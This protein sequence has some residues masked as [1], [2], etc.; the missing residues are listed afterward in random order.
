MKRTWRGWSARW[1]AG[2]ALGT[3]LAVGAC[4]APRPSDPCTDVQCSARGY[5]VSDHGRAYC[6]CLFG[7]HPEGLGCVANDPLDPCLGVTCDGHGRCVDVGGRPLCDCEDGYR[8]P[9]G[10][11]VECVL[12]EGGACE[13]GAAESCNGRDDD[14][15]GLTD[16]VFD[17]DFDSR[18]CGACG[19]PCGTA[20]H[21]I[22]RCTLGDCE[23]TC[24]PGWSDLDRDD[25]NGCEATCE[26]GPNPADDR[27]DGRDDDCDGETDE[28]WS[29]PGGDCGLGIC[30]RELL[31]HRGEV[32]CVPRW[33]PGTT[34]P[35]CD[36]ID[37]DC[38]GL[39]DEDCGGP[40]ADAD[41][42]ADAD[43]DADADADVEVLPWCGNG[44]V[45]GDEECD[46]GNTT[47]L[48]GCEN[49]CRWS[50][51]AAT[52]CE[53]GDPCTADGCTTGGTGR[54]CAHVVDPGAACDDGN[55]C[56]TDDAC[57]DGGTCV[58]GANVCACTSTGD[59]A[60]YEDGDLCNGT[61]VCRA[62]ECVVDAD[63]VVVCPTDLDTTCRRS[64][65]APTSGVCTLVPLREGLACDDGLFCTATDRCTAG[66]CL[67]SGSPC[68]EGACA[69]GCDEGGELCRLRPNG[70]TCRA[71][72]GPCDLAETCSGTAA[73]C[74][75]DVL[76]ASGTTCR[77]AVD[78]CDVAESCNGVVPACPADLLRP[79]GVTC[80]S[81]A[82][83]C[84]AAESCTGSS[85][86][87]PADVALPDG[88]SCGSGQVCSGGSCVT[89]SAGLP[90]S[91]GRVCER[92]TIDCGSGTPVC[93][94]SG[95]EPASTVCRTAAG[96][97][98]RPENCTGSSPDCP[99]D[100]FY[101]ASTPCRAAAGAC[102]VPENCTA[103]GAA[104]PPD[105]LRP[106][107]YT[108][109]TAAGVCDAP[110]SCS[111]AGTACPADLRYG[112]STVCRPE[113]GTCD[114]AE[115][116][117]GAAVGC[118]ADLFLASGTVCRTGSG[119]LCNTDE[120]CSGTAPACPADARLADGTPCGPE[121]C[122]P[123][124]PCT[125]TGCDLSSGTWSQTCTTPACSSGACT[126]FSS[127]VNT[128]A[129][130]PRDPRCGDECCN[131][132]ELG[133]TCST[134]CGAPPTGFLAPGNTPTPTVGNPFGT[135]FE[136]LC[137]TSTS[138]TS[139]GFDYMPE[140]PM[141]GT[142]STCHRIVYTA[143]HLVPEWD[144]SWSVIGSHFLGER[145]GDG[146]TTWECPG[147]T[148]LVGFRGAT[149]SYSGRQVV[150]AIELR[151]APFTIT[152]RTNPGLG[153][154]VGSVTVTIV[155]DNPI[156]PPPS[157]WQGP[158][159]CPAGMVARGTRGTYT[160]SRV[161]PEA[162]ESFGLI[163]QALSPI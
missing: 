138:L 31:C 4:P 68:P 29:A 59:C 16:E 156:E 61:L 84:D 72:A 128:V 49:D 62:N 25:A 14:C 78:T 135:P 67:G 122:G 97:C 81:A 82:G 121:G 134:D 131:G 136:D 56:T 93:T 140:G 151:C 115:A 27:C 99:A 38:D 36:G 147:G 28:G 106:S 132:T 17:L 155:A 76:T 42:D 124:G 127:R 142:A 146:W 83:S 103:G 54:L 75:A 107:G 87:C 152:G 118:P 88:T 35:T 145:G 137:G 91:T 125:G 23:M 26:P 163:C 139:L 60:A 3:L 22:G 110:E 113:A 44:S 10:Y 51:H 105:V 160:G 55:P 8:W 43:V 50:C 157:S 12:D 129:C 20:A 162:L 57:D 100:G 39:T 119:D 79:A 80:R 92:G 69:D 96:P 65:C 150:D 30:R 148:V 64:T 1:A 133:D 120:T 66:V 112:G 101:D 46:D 161:S 108:C 104:C 40:D 141:Q 116:C 158:F 58:G 117:D 98:D 37:E 45:E 48:D 5:C 24:E 6:A 89:C 114:V 143:D 34:D 21:G 95:F 7:Y 9:A 94:A 159:D 126:G 47:A 18:N 154:A 102:D 90:C 11:P 123:F 71:A 53:D 13:V 73:S 33:P 109:R 2:F 86:A 77:A 111:G 74:P 153:T 70:T 32:V 15:D 19:R 63:T 85:P 149:T 41:A 144:A 52:E 130:G